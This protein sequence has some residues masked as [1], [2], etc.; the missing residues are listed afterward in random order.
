M[1]DL[2]THAQTI[3]GIT[4]GLWA[5]ITGRVSLELLSRQPSPGQWS[6]LECLQHLVDTE[7]VFRFRVRAFVAGQ[8]FPDFDPDSQGTLLDTGR[9]ASELARTF[10]SLREESLAALSQIRPADLG[11]KVRHQELG[12]VT[13]EEMIHE[14]AAHDLMHT[15]QGERALMQPFIS[16]SGPWQPYFADHVARP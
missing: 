4:S 5:D 2:L 6:A 11:R 14:W 15:V 10:T 9:P 16:G 1:D 8:D 13:L 3:L 7:P 12:P